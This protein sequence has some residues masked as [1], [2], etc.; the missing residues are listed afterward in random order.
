MAEVVKIEGGNVNGVDARGHHATVDKNGN[1]LTREGSY[2]FDNVTYE[3]TSFEAGDSPATHDFNS[4]AGR[5]AI[6]G[7]VVVDS[8][9]LYCDVSRDGVNYGDKFTIKKGERV[10]LS[11]FNIDKIRITW[12]ENSSYRINLI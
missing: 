3:D 1:L 7:Y 6:D 10:N 5:N 8:G 4:D 12:I 9:S 11:H 2:D